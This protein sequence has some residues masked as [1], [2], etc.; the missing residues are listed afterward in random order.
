[1]E[2]VV[3]PLVQELLNKLHAAV[4]K[5]DR[6]LEAYKNVPL[7]TLKS[8]QAANT[9]TEARRVWIIRNA[10]FRGINVPSAFHAIPLGDSAAR[11]IQTGPVQVMPSA[12]PVAVPAADAVEQAV[13]DAF[14]ELAAAATKLADLFSK[15]SAR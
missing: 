2:N 4:I 7:D 13:P 5:D 14:R 6:V 15:L 12:Q 11:S 10:K 1:M 9:I 8:L 3:N